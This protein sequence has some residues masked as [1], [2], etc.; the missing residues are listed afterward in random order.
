MKSKIN[1]IPVMKFLSILFILFSLT[2]RSQTPAIDSLLRMLPYAQSEKKVEILTQLCFEHR[3]I[4]PSSALLYGTQAVDLAQKINDPLLQSEALRKLG[5]MYAVQAN[6]NQALPFFLKAL[7]LAEQANA[8]DEVANLFSNIAGVYKSVGDLRQALLY[9]KKAYALDISTKNPRAN[10]YWNN[11]GIVYKELKLY[12][13]ALYCYT[14]RLEIAQEESDTEM[15]ATIYQNMGNAYFYKNEFNSAIDFYD[16]TLAYAK[17]TG[18]YYF[19]AK[20]LTGLADAYHE[21]RRYRQAEETGKRALELSITNGF[22]DSRESALKL[23]AKSHEAQQQF[24]SAYLVQVLYSQLKD[25]L[26][27]ENKNEAMAEMQVR[28]ETKLKEQEL[29]EVKKQN[30]LQNRI[31][32]LMAIISVAIISVFI[33]L[34]RQKKLSNKLLQQEKAQLEMARES[35]EKMNL[36][37]EEKLR[38]EIDSKNRELASTAIHLVQKNEI[39]QKVSEG[40][41]GQNNGLGELHKLIKNNLDFDTAW[42]NFQLHFEQVHPQ[43]FSRLEREFPG[44]SGNEL[45]LCSYIKINLSNKEVAQMLNINTTSVEMSRYRLRKKLNLEADTQLNEFIRNF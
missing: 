35:D 42:K 28:F 43:F 44:L 11:A 31:L 16:K 36:L 12:D 29:V 8:K 9:L 27:S 33:L 23:L 7:S 41:N 34:Y 20:A 3:F 14:K 17:Q 2:V 21:L 45:K 13:S 10:S 26:S 38:A 18:N 6:Y 22:L 19:E 39:L 1:F 25:S 32:W 30:T 15:K 24:E 4:K 5:V 40:L 37:R